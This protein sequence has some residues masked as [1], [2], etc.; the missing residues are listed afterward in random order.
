MSKKVN[1]SKELIEKLNT[2]T[3]SSLNEL[4]KKG[5]KK[6]IDELIKENNSLKKELREIKKTH[7]KLPVNLTRSEKVIEYRKKI[8]ELREK[9]ISYSEIAK[10]FNDNKI[11][12]VT[13]RG[14]W[15]AQKV[16]C[17]VKAFEKQIEK[18][19]K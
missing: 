9:N 5:I 14:Q 8:L 19:K 15:Y 10:W 4:F 13:G 17:E 18:E 7:S 1:K 11:P 6:A 3:K 12:T 16:W 2:L